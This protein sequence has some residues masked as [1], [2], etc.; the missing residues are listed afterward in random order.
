MITKKRK[1]GIIQHISPLH[2][3]F[4]AITLLRQYCQPVNG[5][6]HQETKQEG[7]AGG[8]RFSATAHSLGSQLL[9]PIPTEEP[10]GSCHPGASTASLEAAG[11]TPSLLGTHHPCSASQQ[12][13][14]LHFTSSPGRCQVSSQSP[15]ACASN[16]Q[17]RQ[18]SRAV[19]SGSARRAPGALCAHPGVI[20]GLGP[21]LPHPHWHSS[22]FRVCFKLSTSMACCFPTAAVFQLPA[23]SERS[24]QDSCEPP[25]LLAPAV[26]KPVGVPAAQMFISAPSSSLS[27]FCLVYKDLT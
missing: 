24:N 17:G 12:T 16:P 3:T 14:A 26:P 19:P 11:H 25:L 6:Q 1:W 15:S 9:C 8:S 2:H 18:R 10:A 23:H 4:A 20:H 5:S 21:G 27:L 22:S 13:W 7:R